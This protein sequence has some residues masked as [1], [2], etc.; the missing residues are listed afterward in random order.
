MSDFMK[1]LLLSVSVVALVAA[2]PVV[3]AD[4]EIIGSRT[5]FL[6]NNSLAAR[7]HETHPALNFH[8]SD[9]GTGKGIE[10]LV[11]GKTDIAAVTRVLRS[12][13][14]K[15]FAARY[16]R[17]PVMIPVAL[18]GISVFLHPHNGVDELTIDQLARIL[19]G[20]IRNWKEV[21]GANLPIHVCSF[22]RTTGR[23]WYVVENI[24]GKR[25]FAR[26]TRYAQGGSAG[27]DAAR[28]AAQ[29]KDMLAFVSHD[30]SAIG[31]GDLKK[32]RVVK[33]ARIVAADG[34]SYWPTPQN[35]Q[36]GV[37][38]L[39]RAL[40]YLLRD[41]PRGALLDFLRWC[42]AQEELIRGADFV[43]LRR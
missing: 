8:V 33:L 10:A 35:V 26:E 21:G 1:R 6:L 31:Y 23:Y 30:V 2:R 4:V 9:A 36:S 14:K 41:E 24:L 34:K 29:E 32:V 38:P 12:P 42:P 13:E 39:S 22:D 25:S 3:G 15:M 43:P 11:A 18:E 7:F 19:S 17:E 28:L 40:M 37:Y 27:S 16:H 5:M 20:E